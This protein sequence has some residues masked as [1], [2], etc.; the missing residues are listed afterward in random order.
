MF[1]PFYD[2]YAQQLTEIALPFRVSCH[3][4]EDTVWFAANPAFDH[5]TQGFGW[6]SSEFTYTCGKRFSA[7]TG[8]DAM[9]LYY[10]ARP[11]KEGGAGLVQRGVDLYLMAAGKLIERLEI[12][13]YKGP[14]PASGPY[15]EPEE[16]IPG[17]QDPFDIELATISLDCSMRIRRVIQQSGQ[18]SDESRQCAVLQHRP[19]YSTLKRAAIEEG[20][21]LYE[22]TEREI[23]QLEAAIAEQKGIM[24]FILPEIANAAQYKYGDLAEGAWRLVADTLGISVREAQRRK[25]DRDDWWKGYAEMHD[26]PNPYDR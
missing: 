23:A 13:H 16:Q 8:L 11:G 2:E 7:P 5:V 17:R 21:R 14:E 1:N 3:R 19:Q 6:S 25:Q 10:R 9:L 15:E 24:E 4:I 12:S 22:F 26:G 20:G 18:R